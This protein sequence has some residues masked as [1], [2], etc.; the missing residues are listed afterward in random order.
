MVLKKKCF[1]RPPYEAPVLTN[2]MV[3]ASLALMVSGGNPER[4]ETTDA[5]DD[6]SFDYF[7]Y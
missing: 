3:S 4:T 7:N 6:S 5:F 2:F 1:D